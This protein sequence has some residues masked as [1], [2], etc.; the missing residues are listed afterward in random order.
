MKILPA[1]LPAAL[2]R[3][4]VSFLLGPAERFF[5]DPL[6]IPRI[7][8]HLFLGYLDDNP[9]SPYITLLYL[10]GLRRGQAK[11]CSIYPK[12][13]QLW[14][15]D[16][17]E[18]L[19][20]GN[21]DSISSVFDKVSQFHCIQ[22]MILIQTKSKKKQKKTLLLVPKIKEPGSW[23]VIHIK[24]AARCRL[25][26]KDSL[27]LEHKKRFISYFLGKKKTLHSIHNFQEEKIDG[28]CTIK[29]KTLP[30]NLKPPLIHSSKTFLLQPTICKSLVEHD[31]GDSDSKKDGFFYICLRT[32][33]TGTILAHTKQNWTLNMFY[34][35]RET[36]ICYK[37]QLKM[38]P[39]RH[40][41]LQNKF[42]HHLDR[43]L[44]IINR[45]KQKQQLK[46]RIANG[47]I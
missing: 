17:T 35:K 24:D 41:E 45:I 13:T 18:N 33:L 34:E 11:I 7:H 32:H 27:L 42:I 23:N 9:C 4:I 16:L 43:L 36:I 6:F 40:K 44:K 29:V 3:L 30:R 25:L 20:E 28:K 5:S 31:E 10:D 15:Q 37:G 12:Q 8:E 19:L 38:D 21:Q 2:L 26:N 14:D 39:K 22:R 1:M 46:V 47:M